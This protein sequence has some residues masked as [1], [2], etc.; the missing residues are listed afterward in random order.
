MIQGRSQ[1]YILRKISLK[2]IFVLIISCYLTTQLLAI[3]CYTINL[4]L[5][6]SQTTRSWY[7]I[8]PQANHFRKDNLACYNSLLVKLIMSPLSYLSISS[9]FIDS[10]YSVQSYVILYML[11]SYSCKGRGN[12]L[13]L[14]NFSNP[15]QV[16]LIVSYKGKRE[17]RA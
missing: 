10:L 6:F 7:T 2:E 3:Y 13:L 17:R 11:S 14:Y 15:K 9:I 12:R 8:L 1:V 4:S 16:Q 5:L